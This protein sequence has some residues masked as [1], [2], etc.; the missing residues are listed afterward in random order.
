MVSNAH[1]P[2][3]LGTPR[4]VLMQLSQMQQI[5]R[6]VTFPTYVQRAL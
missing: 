3:Y 5:Y 1:N 2:V 4:D 6:S